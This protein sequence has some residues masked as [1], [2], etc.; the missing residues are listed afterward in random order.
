M[1]NVY[2][3][4]GLFDFEYQLPIIFYS[5]IISMFLGGLVQ[6]L[7]LSNDAIIDFKQSEE[8]KNINERTEKLNKKLKNKFVLYFILSSL[9]LL[10]FCYYISIF[11]A[12]Y[13]NTQYILLKDTS[14]GF[15]LSLISPFIMYLIPGFFRIPALAATQKNKRCLYNFSKLF[16]IL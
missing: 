6:M 14:M 8:I 5:S 9:L 11:D 3:S 10:V 1:H 7:G 15:G 4:K 12:V 16:T 2:E 13:I